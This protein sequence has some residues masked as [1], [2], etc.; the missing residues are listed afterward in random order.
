MTEL[1]YRCNKFVL[2]CEN[3]LDE[4]DKNI[5]RHF[6]TVLVIV[7]NDIQIGVRSRYKND[8]E[9]ICAFCVEDENETY[10]LYKFRAYEDLR[11]KYMSR[12]GTHTSIESL[13]RF[14][15]RTRGCL[16]RG[17]AVIE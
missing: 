14:I 1:F 12:H 2:H 4:I 11:E 8:K 5:Q 9:L 6:R 17:W 7:C 16:M 13:A 3:Y 15:F 10:C